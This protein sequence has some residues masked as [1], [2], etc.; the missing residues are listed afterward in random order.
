VTLGLAL[1]FGHITVMIAAVVTS[2]GP[3]LLFRLA[4]RTGQVA[5]I[6]ATT[7]SAPL[8]IWSP[9]LYTVGGLL[10]LATAISFGYN[11]LA[12]W[13]LIAYGLWVAAMLI[14]GA[15]HGPFYRRVRALAA[16]T[17]DGPLTGELARLVGDRRERT[18]SAIDTVIIVAL[19]F[20]MVVKPFS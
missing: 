13:L 10:G 11:V 16:G 8:G 14:G 6:R 15:I 20:D 9:I 5:S 2:F 7:L 4:V 17:P 12:P 1:L 18:A 19:L 3:A